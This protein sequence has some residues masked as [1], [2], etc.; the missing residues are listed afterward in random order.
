MFLIGSVISGTMNKK[1]LLRAFA[2]RLDRIL[3]DGS[4]ERFLVMEALQPVPLVRQEDLLHELFDQLQ[5][6]APDGYYFGCLDDDPTNFGFW[7]TAPT[8][9]QSRDSS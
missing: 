3:P 7:P 5:S 2:R 6:H 9:Q 1:D 4:F 8:A